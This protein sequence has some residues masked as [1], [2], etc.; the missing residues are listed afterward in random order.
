M[1]KSEKER[2]DFAKARSNALLRACLRGDFKRAMRML[3]ADVRVEEQHVTAAKSIGS[4][5]LIAVLQRKG[6]NQVEYKL[7]CSHCNT[8]DPAKESV[9]TTNAVAKSK[10]D[11]IMQKRLRHWRNASSSGLCALPCGLRSQS[12][13]YKWNE[14]CSS[15]PKY[16]MHYVRSREAMFVAE[17]A[18]RHEALFGVIDRELEEES[19][20]L[21]VGTTSMCVAQC[22]DFESL[23][24]FRI[25][26]RMCGY[27]ICDG[28]AF[29]SVLYRA[30]FPACYFEA[31]DS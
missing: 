5:D 15:V 28:A 23:C 25:L 3:R 27:G 1:A 21:Q 4:E 31:V 29:A 22:L 19:K 17:F 2:E 13:R 11:K 14:S 8:D 30:R 16:V 9:A 26:N 20:V 6:F 24:A 12:T 10:A 7:I 18:G